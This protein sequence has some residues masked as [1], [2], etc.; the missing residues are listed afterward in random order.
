M[1]AYLDMARQEA[2]KSTH[3]KHQLGAIVMR[4]GAVLARAANT[5]RWHHCAE[6]RALKHRHH[7]KDATVLVMRANGGCSKPCAGC[8]EAMREAGIRMVV[9]VDRNGAIVA[10]LLV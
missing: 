10:E 2:A 3:P 6:R 9:Y 8:T 4:G 7:F 1:R 5:G